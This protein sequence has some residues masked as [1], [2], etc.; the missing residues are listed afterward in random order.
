MFLSFRGNGI[1]WN[2]GKNLQDALKMGKE[3][4]PET[5]EKLHILTRLSAW[6]FFIK[7]CR[8]EN[9]KVYNFIFLLSWAASEAQH[10]V[11]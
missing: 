7:F 4:A 11:N 6:E 5:S 9:F 8:R 1:Q 10:L 2:V 3:L